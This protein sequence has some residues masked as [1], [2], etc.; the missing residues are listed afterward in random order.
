MLRVVNGA[1]LGV[2]IGAVLGLTLGGTSGCIVSWIAMSQGRWG[3]YLEYWPFCAIYGM[4]PGIPAGALI[5][6]TLAM[7]DDRKRTLAALLLGLGTGIGYAWLLSGGLASDLE[8]RIAIVASGAAGGLLMAAM[9]RGI[10]RRWA[11]WSRW[12]SSGPE[13]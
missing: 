11:W 7:P 3:R 6:G 4:V 9:M 1:A 5:G 10:R 13:A 12:D 2:L 8:V